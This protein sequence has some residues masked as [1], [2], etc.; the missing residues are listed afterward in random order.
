MNTNKMNKMRTAFKLIEE[1]EE[2]SN[3]IKEEEE[4]PNDGPLHEFAHQV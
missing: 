4:S 2:A 3:A 1:E